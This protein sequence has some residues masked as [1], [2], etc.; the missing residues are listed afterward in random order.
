MAICKGSKALS[1]GPDEETKCLPLPRTTARPQCNPRLLPCGP[2]IGSAPSLLIGL[3]AGAGYHTGGIDSLAF[4][5]NSL[6]ITILGL[7]RA[8]IAFN[9]YPAGPGII[10]SGDRKW[11]AAIFLRD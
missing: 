5:K 7:M 1:P 11:T 10:K 6:S 9:S 8:T 4:P 2:R 3:N